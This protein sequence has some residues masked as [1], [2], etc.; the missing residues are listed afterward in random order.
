VA[1]I[2]QTIGE[3]NTI[4]GSIAASVDQQGSAT[5]E[6]ARNVSETAVAA[7]EMADRATEVLAEAEQTG[8]HAGD[9]RDDAASLNNALQALRHA[10]I[11][12]VR[13]ATP[14]VDRRDAARYEVDLTCRITA[15]GQTFS[16]RVADLSDSGAQVRGAQA[17]PA[18]SSGSLDIEG[19]GFAL[20]FSV[21]QGG[22]DTLHLAFALDPA[23]AARFGGMP[24]RLAQ[25]Q[26]A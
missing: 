22:G 4:A 19:V 13:T 5:A 12:V 16:A 24:G 8:I 3:V 14:E 15:G 20:P 7:N 21:K 9:V 1:R 6:I 26:A 2:E 10:V 11:R 23:T 18:G 17:L 25:R